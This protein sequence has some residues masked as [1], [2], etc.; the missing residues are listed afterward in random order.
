[1][2]TRKILVAVALVVICF[3]VLA[4]SRESKNPKFSHT[5]GSFTDPRDG[6]TYET[7]TFIRETHNNQKIERTWY[8]E[9]VRFDVEGSKV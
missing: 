5:M 9:N 6:Q 1:M 7:I 8:A 2:F 3:S 4:Q